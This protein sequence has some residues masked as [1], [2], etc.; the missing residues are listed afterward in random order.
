[1]METGQRGTTHLPGAAMA[2]LLMLT[3]KY[4]YSMASA[5][6][7]KWILAP[8]ARLVA[9]FTDA[10]PVFEA[11]VGFVDFTCG[12][13][14]A[15]ACA[16]INFMIMAFGLA[17]LCGFFHIRR[18][19][20][21]LLWLIPAWIGAY[22]VTLSVNALRIAVSM[23]LYGASIYGGW[24]TAERLHRV[25][26]VAIYFGALW[27]FYRLAEAI[28][29]CYCKRMEQRRP[30]RSRS[31]PNWLPYGG[32]L[33]ITAGV[34]MANGMFRQRP[35]H[36]GEH[37]ATVIA[38]MVCIRL[39]ACLVKRIGTTLLRQPQEKGNLGSCKQPF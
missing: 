11:G 30:D 23:K 36:F 2:A 1:M 7:L 15:P 39:G 9:W 35:I 24:I 20:V 25:V 16:G 6:Q 28:I 18:P 31:L 26:G 5:A 22:G 19:T 13:I 34:P 21:Q 32:Y 14:I 38:A 12:I 4:H 10:R 3:L 17:A 33:A 8:V 29:V 37:V 27:L